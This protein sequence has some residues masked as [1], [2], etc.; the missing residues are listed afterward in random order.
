MRLE[1]ADAPIRSLMPEP[2]FSMQLA[3]LRAAA[4]SER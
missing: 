1:E 3:A 2:N 4:D